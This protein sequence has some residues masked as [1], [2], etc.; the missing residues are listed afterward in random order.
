MLVVLSDH[1][2]W[3]QTF[4]RAEREK[5]AIC[6]FVFEFNLLIFFSFLL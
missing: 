1:F 3:T 4:L 5:K 6:E 2:Y